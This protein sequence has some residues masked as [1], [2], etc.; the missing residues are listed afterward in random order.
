VKTAAWA[1]AQVGRNRELRGAEAALALFVAAELGS[2]LAILVF[3]YGQGG[4]TEAGLAGAA[5]LVPAA[6]LAPFAG[7]AADR[8]GGVRALSAGYGLQCLTLGAVALALAL[9]APPWSV[10]AVAASAAVAMTS[11]RPTHA[12]VTPALARSPIELSAANV[13]SGWTTAGMSLVAP[14][15]AGVLLQATGP[16]TT[17]LAAAAT[18][19]AATVIAARLP[20]EHR[21]PA[22]GG[23]IRST[24]A[25]VAE[26]FRTLAGRRSVRLVVELMGALS[27]LWGALDVLTVSLSLGELDLG[28]K[29][30]GYLTAAF[31]AG[32]IVGAGATLSLIGRRRLV[33]FFLGA[34][35]LC[36]LALVVPG[37]WPT[38]AVAFVLFGAA[39]AGWIIFDVVA[40]TL[41]QRIAPSHVLSRVFGLAEGLTMAGM[42]VGSLLVPLLVAIAGVRGALI[43]VG[44]L[45][46]T[47]V[48]LRLRALVAIDDE[49]VVPVV[50][51][52]LLRGMRLFARLPPP[53][54]EGLARA[55]EPLSVPA[56]TAIVTGGE[57]GDRFYAV[58]DGTVDVVA[59][60]RHV[61]RLGRGEGF[62]EI[63]L[64]H[65]VP[66]T[67][68]VTAATDVRLYA[69]DRERFLV[70][71]TGHAPA[72]EAARTLADE[73]LDEL[74][75]L[76]SAEA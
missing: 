44:A 25:E 48:L 63:A 42:A 8:L 46:P 2:W 5:Q 38:A 58:A 1:L 13:L 15:A 61:A 9:D 54:L 69:L 75:R 56:G 41:L 29:G 20:R 34:A 66:R 10:Y 53:E 19:A 50:E 52:S 49:A 67:A 62:G 68:T 40:Q 43:G 21:E 51:I 3:A 7:A 71:L 36:G 14:A 26:G 47:L 17:L 31:G 70:A 32:G 57:A 45:L 4:A 64:L 59:G 6:L 24:L 23:M 55:L 12:V 65:D 72:H 22:A 18:A 30:A 74:G 76:G 35:S 11:T 73:R 39:G 28:P 60:G 33:P 37:I 16:A 27:V